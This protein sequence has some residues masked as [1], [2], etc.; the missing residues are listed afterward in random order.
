MERTNKCNYDDLLNAVRTGNLNMVNLIF[1]YDSNSVSF[2]N[3]SSSIGGSPLFI[4]VEMDSIEIVKTLL[5]IPRIN[6]NCALNGETIL[7]YSLKKDNYRIA[8]LLIQDERTDINIAKNEESP[9]VIAAKKRKT[10]IIDLL[11]NNPTF[12][13]RANLLDYAF[14][15]S[16]NEIS[17]Q[18][19]S[20]KSLD[21]NF[22]YES[23]QTTLLK[24]VY[25][26]NEEKVDLIINHPSFDKIKSHLTMAI[27]VSI[28]KKNIKIFGKLLRVI[29]NNVN[30]YVTDYARLPLL[31]FALDQQSNEIVTEI[32]ESPNFN[33]D[34]DTI[35]SSFEKL[36]QLWQNKCSFDLMKK[37]VELDEKNHHFIDFTKLLSN[38]KSVFTSM[39]PY[40]NFDEIVKFLVDHG[41]DPNIQDLDDLDSLSYAIKLN[42]APFVLALINSNKIDLTKRILDQKTGVNKTYLHLAARLEEPRILLHLLEKKEMD[43]NAE[44]ENG[45]TPLMESCRFYRDKII[46]ALFQIDDL[47]YLHV[48]KNGENALE[49]V[50]KES[51]TQE[52]FTR[53]DYF[54]ALLN[55]ILLNENQNNIINEEEEE[56]DIKIRST[57]SDHSDL[58][59]YDDVD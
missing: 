53:K 16:D 20:L 25:D 22:Y 27:M 58:D 34:R 56:D 37:I 35:Q 24:E 49:I 11:I 39:I 30:I 43:V 54:Q 2:I 3:N 31:T 9:L 29:D 57:S 8:K 40:L 50:T 18:L 59:R 15:I 47:D 7:V 6:L 45:E 5:S 1:K 26:N 17:K 10:D 44:D 4:A 33:L 48:S 38:G 42:S 14:Y 13:E 51:K 32:L 36:C 21:V 12:D 41:A 46:E 23:H 55:Q 52:K 28:K 19:Y